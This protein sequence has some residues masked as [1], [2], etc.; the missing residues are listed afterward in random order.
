MSCDKLNEKYERW[1]MDE[2]CE[3]GDSGKLVFR[4]DDTQDKSLLT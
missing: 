1:E 3:M 2:F 4:H